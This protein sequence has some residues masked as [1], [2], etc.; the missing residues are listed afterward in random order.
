M[1]TIKLIAAG[2]ILLVSNSIQAQVSVNV[3]IGSTP[4]WGPVGNINA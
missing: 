2:I 1:K 3:N 4:S